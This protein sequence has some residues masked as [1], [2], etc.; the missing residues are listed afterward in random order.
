MSR[1]RTKTSRNKEV[2]AKKAASKNVAATQKIT[3]DTTEKTDA[4]GNCG[5]DDLSRLYLECRAVSLLPASV[6]PLL[7]DQSALQHIEDKDNLIELAKVLNKDVG[8][9]EDEL[10]TIQSK[11]V[12][13]CG[14]TTS[15]TELMEVIGI[16][17]DYQRWL[18]S[19]QM[20]ITPTVRTISQLFERAQ[21]ISS[22]EGESITAD[23]EQ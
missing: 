2:K 21:A 10:K 19:Y 11:H 13:K 18:S 23:K 4:T 17:E 9:F 12:G 22:V 15:T 7:K 5:W 20:V 3:S 14:S 16:G 8:T 1:K 6:S